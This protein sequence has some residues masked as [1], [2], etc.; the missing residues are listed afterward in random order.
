M[1]LKYTKREH[2]LGFY[3]SSRGISFG[4]SKIRFNSLISLKL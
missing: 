3:E 1:K 4:E 2:I